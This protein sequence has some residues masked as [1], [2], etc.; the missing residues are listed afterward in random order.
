LP[1]WLLALLLYITCAADVRMAHVRPF[2]TFS[3]QDLFNNI[4]N[5]SRQGV[6]TLA[7]ELWFFGSPRGLPSPHFGSVSVILTL[8]Q[9]GVA[10]IAIPKNNLSLVELYLVVWFYVLQYLHSDFDIFMC[11]VLVLGCFNYKIM[12]SFYIFWFRFGTWNRPS[13][14]T[15]G[16]PLST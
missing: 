8:P 14:S 5:T 16:T 13:F 9:S 2:S 15:T 1:I 11:K 10:I 6:F 12:I 3:F 7:I 4:K